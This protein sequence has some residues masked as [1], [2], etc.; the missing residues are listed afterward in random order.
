MTAAIHIRHSDL[1]DVEEQQN[2]KALE[3]QKQ[4][5]EDLQTIHNAILNS[6]RELADAMEALVARERA[7]LGPPDET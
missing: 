1:M 4:D 7:K 2:Q 5:L 3:Q 6:M